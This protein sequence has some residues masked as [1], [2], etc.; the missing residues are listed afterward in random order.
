MTGWRVSLKVLAVVLLVALV[1]VPAVAGRA[2]TTAGTNVF[3]GEENL[4]F[5]GGDFTG[6]TQLVHY[7]GKVGESSIDK[8]IM[9][10]AG[11]ADLTGGIPT[12]SYYAIG[13][14]HPTV[15]YVNVQFPEVKLDVVLSN[16][17]SD[18]VNG[19]SVTRNIILDFKLMNNLN[20]LPNGV[21]NIEVTLPDGR[22]T[23]Q[24]GGQALNN[25][26][27]SGYTVYK[28]AIVLTDVSPGIYIAVAKWPSTS[29]FYG[30]GFDSASVAFEVVAPITAIPTTTHDKH[31]T[32]Q[33]KQKQT[34]TKKKTTK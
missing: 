14:L 10:S 30:K 22:K 18:S 31:K 12:G 24:F 3:V 21:M 5:T 7:T 27:V 19:K 16:S 15:T 26:P 11:K 29:D 8:T 4:D 20:G 34:K 2:I 32:Q 6:T 13:S 1:I 23:T 25:I 9:L 28:G 33:K 17:R